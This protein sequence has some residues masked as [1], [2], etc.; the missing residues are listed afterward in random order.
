MW[1]GS[2]NGLLIA[3]H[4]HQLA[5][6]EGLDDIFLS[7]GIFWSLTYFMGKKHEISSSRK[8]S[9]LGKLNDVVHVVLFTR[10]SDRQC[11]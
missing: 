7:E 2:F 5:K 4:A 11:K 10:K 1:N 9:H 8:R 3:L 6:N